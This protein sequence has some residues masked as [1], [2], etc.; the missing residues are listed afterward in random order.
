[1]KQNK[2]KPR[3]T[4]TSDMPLS[5]LEYSKLKRVAAML[6]WND[7]TVMLKNIIVGEP[8]LKKTA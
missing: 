3:I 4:I 7:M 6:E 8:E 1:M 2:F 5:N